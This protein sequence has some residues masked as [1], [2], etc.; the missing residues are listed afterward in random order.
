VWG[1]PLYLYVS[2]RTYAISVDGWDPEQIDQG[3]WARTAR[4]LAAA[5]PEV[6]FVDTF[7]APY[8]ATRGKAVERWLQANYHVAATVPQGHWYVLNR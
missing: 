5:R 1:D 8:I 7:S 4:E 2:G 3:L 6:V